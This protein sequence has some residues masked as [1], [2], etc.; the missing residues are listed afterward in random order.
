MADQ[1]TERSVQHHTFSIER[2]YK[3]SPARVFA[4]FTTK[5]AKLQWFGGPDDWPEG[6]YSLDFRVGGSETWSGGPPGGGLTISLD[7]RFWD[8]VPDQRIVT[9]YTMDANGE[10]MSVSLVTY[11]FEPAGSGTR[12]TLTEAGAFLDA[13]DTADERE[14]GTRELLESLAKYVDG[15]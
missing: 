11:T 12:L 1:T 5:E 6:E 9:T 10:R 14:R 15:G 8:I 2:T 7:Q 13:K 4:A 3:A